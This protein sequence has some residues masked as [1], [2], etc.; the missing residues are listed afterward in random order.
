MKTLY[1]GSSIRIETIFKE[2]FKSSGKSNDLL[3]H[4]STEHANKYIGSNNS[5]YISTS[6]NYNVARRFG[7]SSLNGDTTKSFFIYEII[8]NINIYSVLKT[9]DLLMT[10]F[11]NEDIKEQIEN[12]KLLAKHEKEFIAI[13]TIPNTQ[14]I[15]ANE[16]RFNPS[17]K[18]SSNQRATKEKSG[19]WERVGIHI[20]PK[21][22]P[23]N[24][25][26]NINP[27]GYDYK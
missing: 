24:Y 6:F 7:L 2:G 12:Y 19:S 11:K 4:L 13:S 9:L 26:S 10:K 21:Y 22:S 20:N 18:T 23:N 3:K 17:A 16:F 15:Q 25:T 8:P 27:N 5:N 14:I 1:R